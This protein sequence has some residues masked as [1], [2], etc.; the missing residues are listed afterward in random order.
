MKK[1]LTIFSLLLLPFVSSVQ[2]AGGY[3]IELKPA[4][5]N[6]RDQDSLKRGA[7]LFSN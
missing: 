2:A 1:L 5:N 3:G 7:I 4:E 6:L